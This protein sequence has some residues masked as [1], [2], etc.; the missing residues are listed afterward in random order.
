MG[1]ARAGPRQTVVTC[2]ASR[3]VRVRGRQDAVQAGSITLDSLQSSRAA[4]LLTLCIA[5]SAP[6][7]T[8]GGRGVGG[9]G[10]ACCL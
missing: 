5:W 1:P 6:G 9:V 7:G 4:L 8:G 2:A 3:R 10:S